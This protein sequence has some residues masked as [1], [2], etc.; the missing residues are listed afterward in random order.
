MRRGGLST[1]GS[2]RS[3]NYGRGATDA[4]RRVSRC[5]T[6]CSRARAPAAGRRRF[7]SWSAGC[8]RIPATPMPCSGWRGCSVNRVAVR[9]RCDAI[10]RRWAW[11]TGDA[12]V[13]VRIVLGVT[14]AV[15]L[16]WPAAVVAQNT[17][18]IAIRAEMAS[19]LLQ[20]KQYAE[21]ASEYRVLLGHSP[22]NHSYRLNLIRALMWGNRPREAE[23]ELNVLITQRGREPQLEAML[24]SARQQLVPSS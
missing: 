18:A 4:A 22:G 3:R 21:A 1:R 23:A 8:D 5:R 19:V 24:L 16:A 14:C 2:T 17:R 11:W 20:S 13:S 9:S 6:A 12:D 10:G 7:V 15:A